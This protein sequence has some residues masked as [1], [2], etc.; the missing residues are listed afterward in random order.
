M[1]IKYKSTRGDAREYTASEAIIKGIAD[2]GGLF[3]PNV[4]PKLDASIEELCKMDYKQTAYRI[5]RLFL[6]DFTE[7]ELK[8][9]IDAA[10]DDKF[11]TK[12]IAPVREASGAY[13]LE[14]FHGSTIAFK[15][16]ALSILPHLMITAAKKNDVKAIYT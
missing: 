3:V 7:E 11:D 10:Y 15:D 8:N 12:I 2:D 1:E 13:F 5:M 6:T 16:M 4:I 9:C 14:L